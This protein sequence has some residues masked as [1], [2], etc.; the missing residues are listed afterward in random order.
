MSA[1]GRT[2]GDAPD[3]SELAA[4]CRDA[5]FVRFVAHADGDALAATGLIARALSGA[6]VP[7]QASVARSGNLSRPANTDD[8]TTLLVG[9]TD[10]SYDGAIDAS[11]RPASVTAET[12]ARELAADPDPVCALAGVVA[13]E[14]HPSEYAE[15]LERATERDLVNQRPGVGIPTADLANGLAHTTLAHA[16]FS[17]NEGAATAALADIELPVDLDTRAQRRLASLL[18]LATVSAD[19]ATPRAAEAVE[20]ALH[21]HATD[22][23]FATVEGFADVLDTVAREQP[24]TALALALGHDAKAPALDAWRAHSKRTHAALREAATGRYDGL[25]VARIDDDANPPVRTTARLLRDFRSPEPVALVVAD[26]RA[27]VCATEQQGLLG[28]K[29]AAAAATVS[30]TGGGRDRQGYAEFGADVSAPDFVT[31]F[32]EAL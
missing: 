17:G 20:R 19:G 7:F 18:A 9:G 13:A 29:M 32:R 25:F 5:D 22:G 24:G 27:A 10:P 21:P 3:A 16:P 11:A 14:G 30:G 26:G 1:T 15:L 4:T 31:A 23:P 8:V 12:V 6:G 2:G 28:E